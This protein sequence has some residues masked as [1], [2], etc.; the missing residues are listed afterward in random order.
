MNNAIILHVNYVEQGQ[1]IDEMCERATRW[2]FDGIEF[3]RKRSSAPQPAKEYLDAIAAAQDKHG[4]KRVI[5][6]GPGPN[7]MLPDADARKQEVD[8]YVEF[9]RLAA[10]RFELDVSNTMCGSLLNPAAEADYADYRLHGSFIATDDHYARA[11]EG[12]RQVAAVIEELGVR[13]AFET[14]MCYLHDVPASAM[15]LVEMIGSPAVGVNLD[16]V[17]ISCIPGQPSLAEC[18]EILGD[19]LYYVHLKNHMALR[20]G[21][22]VRCGLG[23]GDTNNREFLRLLKARGYDGP[24]CIEAPRPGDREWFAQQDLAYLRSVMADLG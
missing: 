17:N 9:W 10:P 1:T 18:I 16:Y 23:E 12:F 8:E 5:F 11:A 22:Y 14:H 15:K 19:R 6:G 24:L 2:G 13:L 20:T 21:A 3:R 4:L 7:L